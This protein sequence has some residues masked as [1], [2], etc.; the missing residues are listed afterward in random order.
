M[1]METSSINEST[2]PMPLATGSA[3]T[4]PVFDE[5][6]MESMFDKRDIS[7]E[8]LASFRAENYTVKTMFTKVIYNFKFL[9][10]IVNVNF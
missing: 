6:T 9:V 2:E 1:T 5:S 4:I 8:I 10:F 7:E 3:R